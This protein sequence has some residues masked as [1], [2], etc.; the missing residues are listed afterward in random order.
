[1]SV[2]NVKRLVILFK[3]KE[4][5]VMGKRYYT[6]RYCTVV[7]IANSDIQEGYM[8][9]LEGTGRESKWEVGCVW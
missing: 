2:R 9:S 4:R 3:K 1:M 8:E 7:S 5:R 6:W